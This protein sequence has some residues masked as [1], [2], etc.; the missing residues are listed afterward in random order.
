[1]MM[2]ENLSR[3]LKRKNVTQATVANLIGCTE[4]S[5]RNKLNGITDFTVS[6]ATAIIENILPEFT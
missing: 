6:E 5:L 1:M 4:K 3:E 2:Y